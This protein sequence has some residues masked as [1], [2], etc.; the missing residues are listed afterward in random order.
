LLAHNE[1]CCILNAPNANSDTFKAASENPHL[2]LPILHVMQGRLDRSS[3]DIQQELIKHPKVKAPQAE[4]EMRGAYALLRKIVRDP[5][6]EEDTLALLVNVGILPESDLQQISE[7]ILTRPPRDEKHR[8]RLLGALAKVGSSEVTVHPPRVAKQ[9]NDVQKKDHETLNDA[10]KLSTQEAYKDDNDAYTLQKDGM[11]WKILVQRDGLRP[12][13]PLHLTEAE[14][15]AAERLSSES[16]LENVLGNK[17][18]DAN[19]VESILGNDNVTNKNLWS[20]F[21]RVASGKKQKHNRS[22]SPDSRNSSGND[23]RHIE[24]LELKKERRDGLLLE[25]YKKDKTDDILRGKIVSQAS[26]FEFLGK[27]A[28][29][30]SSAQSLEKIYTPIKEESIVD[31]AQEWNL[32]HRNGALVAII[33]NKA[34]TRDLISEINNRYGGAKNVSLAAEFALRRETSTLTDRALNT[35]KSALSRKTPIHPEGVRKDRGYR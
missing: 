1:N 5:I 31:D 27:T 17:F 25:I 10:I 8:R 9:F 32:D 19:S 13:Q 11:G 34:A 15:A 7:K 26:G 24:S 18:C 23:D 21:K 35:L 33:Q 4:K 12:F 16:T 20:A 3:Q 28:I 14:A 30:A 22:S 29:L 2:S 6:T